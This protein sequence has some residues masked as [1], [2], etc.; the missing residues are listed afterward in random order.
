MIISRVLAS[1]TFRFMSIYVAVLS[2]AGLLVSIAIYASYSYDYFYQNKDLIDNEMGKFNAVYI[3]KGVKGINDFIN[4]EIRINKFDGFYYMIVDS[5]LNKISGNLKSWPEFKNY[6]SDWFQFQIDV[7]KWTQGSSETPYVGITQKNEDGSILLVARDYGEAIGALNLINRV[8]IRSMI[9]TIILGIVGGAIL[10]G[11]SVNRVDSINKNVKAIMSGD[12][13]QRIEKSNQRGDFRE[14]TTN[15]NLMLDRIETLMEGMRQV[16]DNIAHDL[17]TPLTRL[18]N[19]LA[20]LQD[21]PGN[22]NEKVVQNL[23]QEAD[24]ILSTFNALLRIARVESGDQ[25]SGFTEI[26]LKV[27]LLDVIELYEPLMAGKSITLYQNLTDGLTIHG[28]RHLLF[29]AF[30]NVID[31]AIKYTPDT[32]EISIG[33]KQDQGSILITIADTGIGIPEQ[34]K[35]KVFRRFFRVEASRSVHRGNGLGL[36]LVAAVVKLHRGTIELSDSNPG[37]KV[38]IAVPV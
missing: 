13:S 24:E 17:R 16:S 35:K 23:T 18:R 21:I 20:Q 7:I 34:E 22:E 15:L 29:Q 6:G 36:A 31:N 8:L 9:V 4:D 19:N 27:I 25:R 11:I 32:G 3:E 37:L 1:F 28:D 2:F 12:L 30:A 5:D 14:L 33:L 10:A 38:E 26:D